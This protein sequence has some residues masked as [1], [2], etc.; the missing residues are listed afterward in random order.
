M[1]DYTDG[2]DRAIAKKP[3]PV[4]ASENFKD[5]YEDGLRHL[6]G[7]EQQEQQLFRVLQKISKYP[8]LHTHDFGKSE[9]R[10]LILGS[11]CDLRKYMEI[12]EKVI[13]SIEASY[14]QVAAIQRGEI[15]ERTTK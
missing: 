2:I 8:D 5:G 1:S 13:E 12:A 4:S 10:A 15:P 9:V 7:L 14:M 6:V 3:L 11:F